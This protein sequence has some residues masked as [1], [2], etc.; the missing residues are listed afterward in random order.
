[1]TIIQR[2]HANRGFVRAV[3]VPCP[4]H[5]LIGLKGD[6]GR[7]RI[8]VFDPVFRWSTSLG[9]TEGF[10]PMSK[11]GDVAR[12]AAK[13]SRTGLDPVE[14]WKLSAAQVFPNKKSSRNKNCPRCAFL[15]LAE[16][17]MVVGIPRGRYTRSQD[18]KRYA[19]EGLRL[20]LLDPTLCDHPD[21]MWR[22]VMSGESKQHNE[23]M[24]VV[25]ALWKSGDI[26]SA[27]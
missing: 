6:G 9:V 15:G 21:E 25:A 14:A 3:S 16:E 20:L 7:R 26:K 22:R 27:A 4:N 23:Q 5:E 19:V 18:N 1:M 2:P 17:G 8:G 12:L 10:R 24:Q 13:K 11:Y